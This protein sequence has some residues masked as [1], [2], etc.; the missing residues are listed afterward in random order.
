VKTIMNPTSDCRCTGTRREFLWEMG[1]GFAGLALTA[2]LEND[3]F[4]TR[5]SA[6]EPYTNPLA[7]RPP[8]LPARAK[9]CIF[10]FM[11]GGP[12]QVDTF[13]YKPE[14]Q[15]RD[16]QT[17]QIE[18]RR[19]SFQQQRLLASRR[20]FRQHGQSGQWCS[21]AFPNIARHMDELCVVKSL[22]ADTFAHG[23]AMIQM[24]TGR[25]VQGW[26]SIGSWLGYGLGTENQNLPAYVVMLDPRGGPISGAANWSSG[27][28]PAA[29]QGTHLRNRGEPILN[30]TPGPGMTAAM[31][32]DQ[33]DTLNAL[34]RQHLHDRPGYSELEARIAS[35]EL[36]FQL[37][38]TAPEVMDLSGEDARTLELYGI[39]EPRPTN[40]R[41]AYGPSVF[42]R[43]C[44][45]ARRLVERGVRFV[46]IYSGGGHQQENWDAHNGIEEN[47]LIHGPE[48]DRPIHALLT[49]LRRRGLLDET[50][51]VWGGEFGRQPV[52]Q[53]AAGG[54]DHNPKGFT[55]WL[56]GGGARGGTSCG[57]TDPL[58]H[59]AAVNRRHIRDLHAT[60]LH[61]MGL[62]H[63]RLT[64]FY[65]GLNHRLTGVQEAHVI[66]ECIA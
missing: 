63:H 3:G 18:M 39:N 26:P 4:F 6:S 50:L 57:E 14:L 2:L 7:P 45:I 41:L 38:S 10:L 43:Q 9:H 12:S 62:D 5:A 33:V 23:S 54:R 1:A 27:F 19:H 25:I 22:Y 42:G 66:E 35:Y 32:R 31:E 8:H 11:Y 56:A 36:A 24:N 20:T 13:D 61:L 44:L 51:I 28:M 47:L 34:N 15:G 37:Q 29:Y 49:D 21:D 17:V 48:I 52:S 58:G 55:Y 46:Q 53:G 16:G 30:L 65:G 40:H 64:Y 60:I 59:E